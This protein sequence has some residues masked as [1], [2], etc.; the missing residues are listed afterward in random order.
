MTAARMIKLSRITPR[1]L[2]PSPSFKDTEVIE[3]ARRIRTSEEIPP[4]H[5]A[6]GALYGLLANEM[7]WR[8]ARS[9]GRID[10]PA[11][12]HTGTEHQLRRVALRE[13]VA[14]G[15]ADLFAT[16]ELILKLQDEGMRQREFKDLIGL[17]QSEI[18]HRVRLYK[19]LSPLVKQFI[20]DGELTI[21]HGKILARLAHDRQDELAREASRSAGKWSVR[22][23]EQE[24]ADGGGGGKSADVRRLEEELTNAVG[25]P[26]QIIEGPGKRVQVQITCTNPDEAEGVFQRLRTPPPYTGDW[27]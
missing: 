9:A 5:V 10:F 11:I 3:L 15:S 16:V 25:N 20:R 19:K 17:D 14:S 22:R 4:L 23:L 2:L 26:V 1:D 18:G 13:H 21:G 24:M 27:Y 6:D 12:I 7:L 8:A